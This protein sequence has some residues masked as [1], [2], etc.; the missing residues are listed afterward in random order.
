MGH[1]EASSQD[2]GGDSVLRGGTLQCGAPPL[3][4]GKTWKEHGQ[5]ATVQRAACQEH[6]SGVTELKGVGP[7]EFLRAQLA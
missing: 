1:L 6:P 3:L 7:E 4:K 5:V 2:V